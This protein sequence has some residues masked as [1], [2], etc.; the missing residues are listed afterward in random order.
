M[1]FSA[2]ITNIIVLFFTILNETV[3]NSFVVVNILNLI[4]YLTAFMLGFFVFWYLVHKLLERVTER[5]PSNIYGIVAIAHW[6]LLAIMSAIVVAECAVY[7]AYIAK[8]FINPD[9][10]LILLINLYQLSSAL[11]II[12]WIASIEILG[13]MIF[14]FVKAGTEKRVCTSPLHLHYCTQQTRTNITTRLE[15]QLLPSE[16][17]SSLSSTLS[18]SSSKSSTTS[19]CTTPRRTCPQPRALWSSSASLASTPVSCWAFSNGLAQA[20]SASRGIPWMIT[21]AR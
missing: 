15:S 3:K 2:R 21:S 13:F 19:N 20:S 18:W 14:I 4:F 10:L 11:D 12:C 5:S 1:I 9:K 16:P 8:S 7:I 17:S 6:V